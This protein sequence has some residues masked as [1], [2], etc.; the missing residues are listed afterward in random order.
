MEFGLYAAGGNGSM[1]TCIAAAAAAQ[2]YHV[3]SDEFNYNY[4]QAK[5]AVGQ[6]NDVIEV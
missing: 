6:Y 1:V 3:N 2:G 4:G 5:A